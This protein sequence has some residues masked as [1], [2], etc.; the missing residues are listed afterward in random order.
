M[1]R[2]WESKSV[3]SQIETSQSERK[4]TAKNPVTPEMAAAQRKKETL[5]LAR[6]HLQQQMQASQ[7][8]RY[9]ELLRNALMDLEKQIADLGALDR[10]AGSH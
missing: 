6:T 5:L 8:P 3:E 9:R 4:E 2:G 1:A 7:H 10:A